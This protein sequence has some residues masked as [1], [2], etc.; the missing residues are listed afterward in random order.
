MTI[1]SIRESTRA[2]WPSAFRKSFTAL[3]LL[4]FVL[5]SGFTL[6]E[7][8]T[9]DAPGEL[10]RAHADSP[11]LKNCM[12]CHTDELEPSAQKCLACHN[13]IAE[14]VSEKRGYHKDNGQD[15]AVC[16]AEHQGKAARLAL[17]DSE[18]F[19]HA[20]TG[21]TLRGAHTRIS[22]CRSCHTKDN[23]F[24]R[25]TTLS[26]LMKSADCQACHKP[27][28]PGRQEICL[29]CHNQDN[30]EVDIWEVKGQE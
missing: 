25:K 16:H 11:G 10:S 20:E 23:T 4:A 3:I 2:D 19:D 6:Q 28:H 9:D 26:Y 1:G 8:G 12:M 21:Y 30:W 29:K 17:L 13:E 24:P 5:L 22:D 27:P 15:C 14:R 18:N 7:Y